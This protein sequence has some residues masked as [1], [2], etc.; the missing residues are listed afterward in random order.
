MSIDLTEYNIIV[1]SCIMLY[2]YVV[3]RCSHV[4]WAISWNLHDEIAPKCAMR[5]TRRYECVFLVKIIFSLNY[6]S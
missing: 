6:V 3:M 4:F 5:Q 1:N 2:E